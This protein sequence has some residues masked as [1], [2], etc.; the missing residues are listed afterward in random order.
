MDI[1]KKYEKGEKMDRGRERTR[2]KKMG[3]LDNK[4][5][6]SIERIDREMGMK[7][8]IVRR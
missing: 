5:T 7:E 4:K 2:E 1:E 3:K 6:G 8:S